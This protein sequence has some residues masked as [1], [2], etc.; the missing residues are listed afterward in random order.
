MNCK[1]FVRFREKKAGEK[2]SFFVESQGFSA[3]FRAKRAVF[4]GLT[5]QGEIRYNKKEKEYPKGNRKDEKDRVIACAAAVGRSGL[6]GVRR[7]GRKQFGKSCGKRRGERRVVKG[8][9][10]GSFFRE[11]NVFGGIG[12]GD[13]K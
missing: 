6:R 1:F 13:E 8:R 9:T 2:E 12:G 7:H 4:S 11:R 10:L 3:F 5:K